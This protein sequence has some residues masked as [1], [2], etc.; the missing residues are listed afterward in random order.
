VVAPNPA[1]DYFDVQIET[2]EPDEFV[3]LLHDAQGRLLERRTL[4]KTDAGRARFD[5]SQLPAGVYT[6]TVSSERGYLTQVVSKI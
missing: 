3:L 6:L 2:A 1:A 5:V 4:G